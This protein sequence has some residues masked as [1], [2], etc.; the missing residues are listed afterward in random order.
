MKIVEKNQFRLATHDSSFFFSV[1]MSL[2]AIAIM[3]GPYWA[4][5]EIPESSAAA[6][7]WTGGF[8]LALAIWVAN[9]RRL[10]LDADR[11]ELV[12]RQRMTLLP[13]LCKQVVAP[14]SSIEDVKVIHISSGR[15]KRAM[16]HLVLTDQRELR[17]S[18]LAM[19]RGSA[20]K[21]REQIVDWIDENGKQRTSP[22]LKSTQTI[23]SHAQSFGT[24]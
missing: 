3:T 21:L 1:G 17:L 2:L 12:W 23:P 4:T 5:N 20:H 13:F 10:I 8:F 6:M 19:G 11:Q 22:S 9:S 18:N 24:Q 14:F 15:K 16:L 7:R